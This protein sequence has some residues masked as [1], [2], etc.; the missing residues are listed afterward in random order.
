MYGMTRGLMTAL[1]AGVAGFLIW[2]ASA[3][4]DGGSTGAYWARMGL[5]AGAGLVMA[6]SQLL[7]GWTKWG[8]PRMSANVFLWGFLPTLVCAG[9]VLVAGAPGGGWFHS[10][11]LSWSGAIGIRGLVSDLGTYIGVLAFGTGLVFG[12]TFDTTGS[13]RM[14]APPPEERRELRPKDEPLTAERAAAEHRPVG[15]GA[16]DRTDGV[17]EPARPIERRG[18]LFRR[19]REVDRAPAPVA[20]ETEQT[21]PE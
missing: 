2:M 7:G 5:L 9:W 19:R 15:A 6:F 20:D 18:G 14:L 13:R 1:G 21:A 4:A 16:V 3:W 17:A 11:V 10:H 8:M 12:F